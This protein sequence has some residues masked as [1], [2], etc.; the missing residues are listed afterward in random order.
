MHS[1][2]D[3]TNVLALPEVFIQLGCVNLLRQHINHRLKDNSTYG[4]NPAFQGSQE[5][6]LHRADLC[7]ER[8]RETFMCW[9]DLASILQTL[10]PVAEGG[11]PRSNIDLGSSHKCRNFDAVAEW[12]QENA[13]KAVRM[14]DMWWG[15]RKFY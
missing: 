10:T 11:T 5:D 12:T 9:G 7:I 4:K 6:V 2:R 1:P 13:V 8:L 3:K 15:G 14:S